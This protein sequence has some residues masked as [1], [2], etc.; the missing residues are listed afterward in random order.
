MSEIYCY[1]IVFEK[2]E[3]L[4]RGEYE[5]C[6]FVECDFSKQDFS[7]FVF[8]DC[9]F[10]ECNL[11]LVNLHKSVIRD[12]EFSGCKMMGLRF[13]QCNEF[14]LSFTFSGC[15]LNHSSFYK[16]KIKN[17]VFNNS[18]LQE[19]DFTEA[20]LSGSTFHRC[21]F[22]SATFYQTILEKSDLRNS[23]NYSLDPELNRIKKARFS[24]SG[25]S[26]LLDKYDIKIED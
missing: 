17:T 20:D 11:S 10:R 14:G 22:L 4:T 7:D 18:K 9:S 13:E 1:D 3:T 12:V 23:F 26:G 24:A 6:T 5:C 2:I 16:L 15:Q 8:I 19:V 25:I 21:D